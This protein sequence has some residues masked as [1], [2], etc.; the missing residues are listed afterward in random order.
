MSPEVFVAVLLAAIL[1]ASWNAIIKSGEDKFAAISLMSLGMGL[2]SLV[3]LP[4]VA[5]PG[6]LTWAWIVLSGLLHTGYKIMLIRA[7]SA[8]DLGQIYPL[9]RGAAPMLAT[10]LAMVLLGEVASPLTLAG[11]AVVSA[12]VWL[13]SAHGGSADRLE[14][15]AVSAALVTSAFIAG[16]TLTDGIGARGA[17]SASSYAAWMFVFDGFGMFAYC[18]AVRG[19]SLAALGPKWATG[20]ATGGFS[21]AAYW[22]VIWAMTR[23][24]IGAVAALRETSIL[25]ALII[26][27]LVLRERAN[28][29]RIFA[30]VVIIIGVVALRL[31]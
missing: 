25:F 3:A 13:M 12:G 14:G 15:K 24:P 5:V 28:R 17:V 22:I 8:G 21:I 23:A 18:A 4:F 29:W 10:V 26:S 7:Y 27:L 1:H 9:A 11:I 19:R 16:Y 30:A 2:V 31:G 20:I 6:G